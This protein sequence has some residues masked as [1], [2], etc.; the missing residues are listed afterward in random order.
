VYTVPGVEVPDSVAAA[1]A[2][3][4]R[5]GFE[6]SSEPE[7]GQLIACLAHAVPSGGRV[8]EIGTDYGVGLAWIVHGI[9]ARTDVEVVSVELDREIA[10]E[11]RSAGWP[12]W[13]SILVGDGADLVGTVGSFDLV[14]PD[15]PGGKVF[16]L[17]KTISTLRPGS[18]LLVDDMDLSVHDDPELRNGLASVRERLIGH[19]DLVCAELSF[20]SGVIVASKRS[21]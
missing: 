8:L 1:Q 2:H 20:A 5:L 11:T 16:K 14:F 4:E 12:E 15:A 17:R 21:S 18:F 13:V 10:E 6:L 7:V 19:P 9:G 3:A